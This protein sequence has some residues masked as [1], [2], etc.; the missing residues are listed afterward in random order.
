MFVFVSDLFVE[1]YCGG[2]ELT[3]EAIIDG[4]DIPVIKLRS[5]QVSPH[6]ID[7]LKNRH[8]IFGNFSNTN[9]QTIMYCCKNL[10]YSVIEYDYKYCKY[11]LS[12][13]HIAA[14][15]KCDCESSQYGKMISIFF[16]NAK[17]L[18]FMSEA[19]K[20]VYLE[21][22]PFLDKPTTKVLS[23]VFSCETLEF[24]QQKNKTNRNDTWLIQDSQS[25]VKGTDDAVK[26][27]KANNLK[28]E[29]FSNLSH[30]EVLDKFS[31]YK[32]FIFLPRG[33]DT[34]PRT[35][36]EAKLLGCSL[37]LNENVQHKH[38]PWFNGSVEEALSYLKERPRVFWSEE[39]KNVRL[40]INTAENED[41]HFKIVV[42]VC[43]S[44]QWI[45]RCLNSVKKQ[46]YQNYQCIVVDDMST[47][48]TWSE[49]L[50][51]ADHP[52]FKVV[53]NTEKKYALKNIYD[54]VNMCN[55]S[56]SDVIV[57]LDGDDWLS[58][59]RVLSKLSNEYNTGIQ[60]TYGS[61]V[62][63]PDGIIGQESSQY[64]KDVIES[65]SFREDVWR[66]SHLRT[67]KYDLW[68][69]V[70]KEDLI[71]IDGKFYETSYDQAM[72]L[73]MLEMCGSNS[74]FIEDILCVYNVGNPNAVNKIKQQKQY[75]TML[76][77]RK[78]DKY[79]SISNGS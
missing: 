70:K 17:N 47:D 43:N 63:Y 72:M 55:P 51:F 15:G 16:A 28:Y 41:T 8:W 79:E 49:I 2:G 53:K 52:N 76:R 32:G 48:E 60:M 36:I 46:E 34:C 44:E 57:V 69:K 9:I 10:S 27:A 14:E 33:Y 13:K 59:S 45:S 18:W 12:Q 75:E 24:M 56:N 37:I 62:R 4:T 42:P 65:N 67:F 73:P 71:D 5:Q 58:N 21:F 30:K 6:I 25:W 29:L 78:K 61:F 77:I 20:S 39:Y 11:R 40:P 68:S 1:D 23:S 7:S 26:F 74:K 22:Y 54:S 35:V 50:A 19:Q 3:S 31:T 38:E 66:A 64:P